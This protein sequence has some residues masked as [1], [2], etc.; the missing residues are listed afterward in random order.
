MLLHVLFNEI[1][2]GPNLKAFQLV[3]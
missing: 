2:I 1:F 3:S